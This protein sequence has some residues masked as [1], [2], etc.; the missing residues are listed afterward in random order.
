MV[1]E[2]SGVS[3][4]SSAKSDRELQDPL[5][6]DRLSNIEAEVEDYRGLDQVHCSDMGPQDLFWS[7]LMP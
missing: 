4:P 2:T 6:G 7:R 5:I 3:P 1:G